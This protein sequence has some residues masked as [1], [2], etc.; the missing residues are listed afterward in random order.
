MHIQ[1]VEDAM[2]KEIKNMLY[3][4]DTEA[5]IEKIIPR[6]PTATQA[7]WDLKKAKHY[8][9]SRWAGFPKRPP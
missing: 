4:V 2:E 7:L 3:T 5:F 6:N 9:A 1:D 8:K